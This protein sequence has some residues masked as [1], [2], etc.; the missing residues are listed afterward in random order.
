L[1][2]L[3]AGKLIVVFGAGGDRDR[4]KRPRMGEAA[5]RLA[6]RVIITSDNPRSED[7]VAIMAEIASGFPTDFQ[8]EAVVSRRDALKLAVNAARKGDNV[9]IAGKGHENYQ[10][11]KGVKHHFDDREVL[12]SLFE[13]IL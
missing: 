7:P 6:D 8:F 12:R 1:R 10:E 9:L 5:A 2:P 3:T 11:I 4:S 13:E